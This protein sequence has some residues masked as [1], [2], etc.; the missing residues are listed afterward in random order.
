MS[1]RWVDPKEA[2]ERLGG[3]AREGTPTAKETELLAR[4]VLQAANRTQAKGSTTRLIMPAAPEVAD[5]MGV[6]LTQEQLVTAEEYLLE[7]DYVTPV[8]IAL[9]WGTYTITPAGMGWLGDGLRESSTTD[10]VRELAERPGEEAAF[11]LA[12]RA[13]LEEERRRIEE[14]ERKLDEETPGGP[15]S[16]AERPSDTSGY[17][18]RRSQ[19]GPWWKRVFGS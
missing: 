10:R 16:G 3:G 19:T 7:R 17:A 6:E 1:G 14:F 12:L 4:V 11:E 13:E 15:K 18:V 9:S 2:A 5:E 8:D